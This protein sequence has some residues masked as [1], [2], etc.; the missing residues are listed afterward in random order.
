M[1]SSFG[2]RSILL[3]PIQV[4]TSELNLRAYPRRVD[5]MGLAIAV[6]SVREKMDEAG[7]ETRSLAR[8]GGL[9]SN[10]RLDRRIPC[11]YR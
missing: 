5:E 10:L 4:E 8:K 3:L 6:Y 1:L 9:S 2:K 11:L 7:A